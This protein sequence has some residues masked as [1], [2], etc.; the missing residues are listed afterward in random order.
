MNAFPQSKCKRGFSLIEVLI[1]TSI[2]AAL[3]VVLVA[4]TSDILRLWRQSGG[5]LSL[6]S[7]AR[8]ALEIIEQDFQS[9]LL[10]NDG[11]QWI[12]TGEQSSR[13]WVPTADTSF[14]TESQNQFAGFFR[15]SA[16]GP[17][18]VLYRLIEQP[19][20]SGGS[21]DVF[22]LVRTEMSAH[23][24]LLTPMNWNNEAIEFAWPDGFGELVNK[25]DINNGNYTGAIE[26]DP[27]V[28]RDIIATRVISLDLGF[29][30]NENFP[31]EIVVRLTFLSSE[32]EQILA[33][34][35]AGRIALPQNLTPEEFVADVLARESQSF[36]KIIYPKA[37]Q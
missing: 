27:I 8:L 30:P 35:E 11:R 1:A 37:Q 5:Q 7:E 4:L 6:N 29:F 25:G 9:I 20:F 15:N 19:L 12:I 16:D 17:K 36:R 22:Q 21:K 13:D 18:A 33:N 14:F 23:D 2:T 24:T 28:T 3:G 26:E 31:R 34:Y 10:R 32:G